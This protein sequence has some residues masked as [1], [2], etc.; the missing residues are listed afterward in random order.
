[1]STEKRIEELNKQLETLLD[2]LVVLEY[3]QEEEDKKN[4]YRIGDYVVVEFPWNITLP[5]FGKIGGISWNKEDGN[6]QYA[7]PSF[8]TWFQEEDIRVPTKEELKKYFR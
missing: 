5:L 6:L 3:K 1:M 7:I 2:E 4:K 8:A